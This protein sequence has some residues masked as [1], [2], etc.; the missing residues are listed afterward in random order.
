MSQNKYKDFFHDEEPNGDRVIEIPAQSSFSQQ[1]QLPSGNDPMGRV[2][3]EGRLY[4]GLAGGRIPWWV[5][6]SG[7]VIFGS[8]SLSTFAAI[9]PEFSHVLT[10]ASSTHLDIAELLRKSPLVLWSGLPFVF[11]VFSLYIVGRGT[12]AKLR[13]T[14]DRQQRER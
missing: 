11:S 6:I 14:F 8:I 2:Y 10:E 5:L 13:L 7:W 3:L 9:F 1:E 12:V 4:R